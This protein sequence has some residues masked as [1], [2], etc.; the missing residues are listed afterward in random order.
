MMASFTRAPAESPL[1]SKCAGSASPKCTLLAYYTHCY[2]S[3][4]L[5]HVYMLLSLT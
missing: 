3:L 1:A 2:L 5:S 4:G